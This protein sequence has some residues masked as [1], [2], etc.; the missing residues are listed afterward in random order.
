MTYIKISALA[1]IC[2]LT[3]TPA[4]YSTEKEQGQDHETVAKKTA[5]ETKE[6]NDSRTAPDLPENTEQ[7]PA[8]PAIPK[9][10]MIKAI[11]KKNIFK[12]AL[13]SSVSTKNITGLFTVTSGPLPLVRPFT[14][15]G[16]NISDKETRAQLLFSNPVDR[17]AA[18]VGEIIERITITEI[19]STYIRC[20]YDG[21]DVKMDV[22]ESSE[23][24]RKRI[25]GFDKN[26]EFI[27]TTITDSEAFAYV[28]IGTQLKRLEAGDA[29]GESE[30]IRIEEGKL[31]IRH[32]NGLEFAIDPSS[33]NRKA[34]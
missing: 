22:G 11:T 8:L 27:G 4:C 33:L 6:T 26:F 25:M 13:F 3:L 21:Y 20:N 30:I 18:S 28:K 1:L 34:Q 10:D 14:L 9:A 24:A 15:I 32:A 5:S 2:S 29:L 12:P 31:W 7:T 23:D 16:I 17:K 19:A